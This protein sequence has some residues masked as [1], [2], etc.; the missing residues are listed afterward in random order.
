[1]LLLK[2]SLVDVNGCNINL[3]APGGFFDRTDTLF[4]I[5]K[6]GKAYLGDEASTGSTAAMLTASFLILVLNLDCHNF[7]MWANLPIPKLTLSKL[8]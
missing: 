3:K 7:A 8:Y 4:K 5:N 6:L 2:Q 1:M